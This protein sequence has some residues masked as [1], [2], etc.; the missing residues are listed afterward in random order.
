MKLILFGA[1]GMIGQGALRAALASPEVE[2]VLSVARRP[3]GVSNAKLTEL[4]H[5]D[6]T[7]FSAVEAEL[8]GYDG[9]LFCLGV[10]SAGMSEQ[11]YARVTF[12][13]TLAAARTLAR[14]N[15]KAPF[16]Y[17]SGQGTDSTERGRAMWARVKGRTENELLRLPVPAYLFRPGYIQP[18]DGV[19]SSTTLYRVMYATVG[20]LYP[21]WRALA[22][23]LVT[24]SAILGRAMV[25]AIAER[26]PSRIVD[27]PEINRLG[28]G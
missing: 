15:P 22:P 16:L 7:D 11:D 17:V 10:S 21:L 6:F 27:I 18:V 8:A 28:A 4:L 9:C 1:T 26:G 19:V 24:T 3:T 13:Y 20:V 14:L 5:K 25:A 12:D 2:R 23:N